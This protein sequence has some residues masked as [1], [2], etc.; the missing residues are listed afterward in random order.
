MRRVIV[1][2]LD[3]APPDLLFRRLRRSM[4]NIDRMIERGAY[5]SLRSCHPP[6]TVP[7]WLAMFTGKDPGALGLYGLRRREGHSYTGET[8]ADST[9]T[10]AKT[11]WDIAG[12]RGRRVAIV[13]VPP[14]Y[15]P[16]KVNGLCVSCFLT[17]DSAD[18]YTYPASLT[19]EIE[20]AAGR[21][22]FDVEFRVE[23]RDSLRSDIYRMTRKH[24]R[25]VQHLLA[26][27][28]WD[29]FAF[30]EIGVDRIQHAFWKFFDHHHK[31]YVPGNR[32]ETV[33]PD[34]YALLDKR[35]GE[36]TAMADDAIILVVSD[37][38]AKAMKGAF[39]VNEWLIREGYLSL[40]KQPE[41]VVDLEQADVDWRRTMAWG[42][43]GYYARI[44]LNVKG[45]ERLGVVGRRDYDSV[46]EEI[47]ERLR[48][49]KEPAGGPMAIQAYRPEE[50]YRAC[51]GDA[52]DMMVYFDG[53]N[54][55]S[56]G[57]IGHHRLFL[58]DND[59]GPDDAVHSMDGV[60]LLYDPRRRIG[61]DLGVVDIM[62]VA[63]TLLLLMR[64]PIPA[65]VTGKPLEFV[66]RL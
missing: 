10:D 16:R 8:I 35:I 37:H 66:R 5:G 33:I 64:L 42:W 47:A 12:E 25:V 19:D 51:K 26:R 7:A 52:P 32:Y 57:T 14:S 41:G 29:F 15:P 31:R 13:G 17:P 54:Y 34:Y 40:R 50:L 45:R 65:G 23:D 38:G 4:P 48:H 58:E 27:E 30:V 43:G 55:R 53:L 11:V 18:A 59:N 61:L 20:A 21:Y 60:F 2:G 9:K 46:R 39:C 62:D 3:A 36:I 56:A 22:E 63:P 28:R 6:I 49:I 1:I 24:F 44:F